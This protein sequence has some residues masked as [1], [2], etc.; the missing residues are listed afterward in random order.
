MASYSSEIRPLE[1]FGCETTALRR[2]G[3]KAGAAPGPR[4]EVRMAASV[5]RVRGFRE[6][7]CIACSYSGYCHNIQCKTYRAKVAR[8]VLNGGCTA[9]S[10]W[11]WPLTNPKRLRDLPKCRL[12]GDVR[13][14]WH[15]ATPDAHDTRDSRATYTPS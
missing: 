11:H 12:A 6:S 10:P 13:I 1:R 5:Y 15:R 7:S 2:L 8:Y 4:A 14:S 3:G 9:V